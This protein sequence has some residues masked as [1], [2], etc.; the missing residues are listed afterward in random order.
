MYRGE[1]FDCTAD[2][3]VRFWVRIRGMKN[4]RRL[5]STP[6]PKGTFEG[7]QLLEG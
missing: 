4:K 1:I 6:V 5:C 3:F 7:N 2:V